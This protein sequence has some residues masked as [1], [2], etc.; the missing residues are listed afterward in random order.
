MFC[1][2]YV[3]LLKASPQVDVSPTCSLVC[4]SPVGEIGGARITRKRNLQRQASYPVELPQL[5]H[6][7]N[8]SD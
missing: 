3:E 5:E 2:E 6:H 4:Q 7:L 1:C 8:R